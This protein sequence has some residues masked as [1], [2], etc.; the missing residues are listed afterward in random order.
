VGFDGDRVALSADGPSTAANRVLVK[1]CIK[2]ER[3]A[4]YHKSK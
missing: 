3:R 4:W 2:K 1:E